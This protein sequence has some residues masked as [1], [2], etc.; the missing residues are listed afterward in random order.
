MGVYAGRGEGASAEPLGKSVYADVHRRSKNGEGL[1]ITFTTDSFV[2]RHVDSFLEIHAEAGDKVFVD[3]LPLNHTDAII[4]LLRH[5][6]YYLRRLA[7]IEKKREELKLTKANRNDIK[8]LMSIEDR[9]FRRVSEDFLIMRRLITTFRTLSKTHQ[10]FSNK[11][12][13]VSEE[14]RN[15]LK[16]VIK[17]I[18]EQM[19]EMAAKIAEEAGKRYP[20]YDR[21]VDGLGIRGNASAMEALAEIISYIDGGKGFVKTA[22]LFGLFKPVRGRM[23]IYGRR[24][25]QA[26]HRLTASVNGITSFQLTA[27]LE[28]QTLYRVWKTVREAHGRLAIPAQQE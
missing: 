14:E 13:A 8:V 19:K 21:L 4:E 10:Q 23:K 2:F 12:R 24:L 3:I 7:L 17:S 6:V 27:R 5:E 18:E 11:C 15:M 25:R 9:W 1:R 16:P 26:L 28:K 20:A 22:N